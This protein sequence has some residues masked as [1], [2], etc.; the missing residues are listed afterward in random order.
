MS[1]NAKKF[2]EFMAKVDWE[3]G[4][5]E[6]VQH[7]HDGSGDAKLDALLEEFKAALN[8]LDRRADALYKKHAKAIAAA[9]QEVEDELG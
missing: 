4:W 7:G 3:G 6:I 5:D 8:A 9:E 2:A 1:F